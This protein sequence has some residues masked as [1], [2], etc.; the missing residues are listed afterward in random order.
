[1]QKIT[2]RNSGSFRPWAMAATS[3]RVAGTYSEAPSRIA[4]KVGWE[5]CGSP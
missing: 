2:E 4:D 1:V 5:S 3:G